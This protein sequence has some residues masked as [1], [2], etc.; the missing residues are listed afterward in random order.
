M[1][2]Y[3]RLTGIP[4]SPRIGLKRSKYSR[5]KKAGKGP[6]RAGVFD[7]KYYWETLQP[8]TIR[9]KPNFLKIKKYSNPS[10]KEQTGGRI[11]SWWANTRLRAA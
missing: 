9:N 8:S 5:K 7:E 1:P 3:K 6:H 2:C 11:M 4:L 10:I